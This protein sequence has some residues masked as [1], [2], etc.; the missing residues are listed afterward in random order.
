MSLGEAKKIRIGNV[1]KLKGGKSG[2]VTKITFLSR[3]IGVTQDTIFVQ[4]DDCREYR[5]REIE[6]FV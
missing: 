6:S 4:L 3:G 2:I 5:H 1:V